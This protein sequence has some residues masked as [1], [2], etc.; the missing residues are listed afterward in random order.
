VP[1]SNVHN[2]DIKNKLDAKGLQHT[3]C[4][5]YRTLSNNFT[6]EEIKTFDYDMLIF[7]TPTGVSYLSEAFPNLKDGSF[8]LGAFVLPQA[9]PS[10]RPSC[11]W[12]SS[13]APRSIP[14][15]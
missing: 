11:P 13:Q 6:E 9:R 12:P 3:E 5:M 14:R 8:K 7:S 1:L 4:T 2:D 15:W 10:R